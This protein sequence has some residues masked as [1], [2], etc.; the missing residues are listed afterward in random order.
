MKIIKTIV[1]SDGKD[2]GN[3]CPVVFES[4][5][6]KTKRLQAIAKGFGVES[7]F[8]S[9][10]STKNADIRFRYFV[11]NHEMEMCV[12]ATVGAV[13]FLVK[14]KIIKKTTIN[15]QTALGIIEVQ[16][17]YTNNKDVLVTVNQFSPRFYNKNPS[18]MLVA[19]ALGINSKMID[20]SHYPLQSVSTS[21]PKLIVPLINEKVLHNL[22]PDFEK[23]WNLCD[24]FDTT[25]FYP[26]SLQTHDENYDSEARQFPK[27][28]GYNEDPATGVAACALGA[29]L[30]FYNTKKD[31]VNDYTIGQGKA[32]GKPSK[33]FVQTIIDDDGNIRTMVGGFAKIVQ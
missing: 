11:P 26:F 27:N 22:T 6:L 3:P 1:F 15:I 28:V 23:L 17:K 18:K 29:Y 13:T 16:W 10:P 8:L 7:V 21:R 9:K 2:G 25:G 14:E 24:E 33:I 20:D 19:K 12:H 32:L 4:D 30:T 31:K 5:K